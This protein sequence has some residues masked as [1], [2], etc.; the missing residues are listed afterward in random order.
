M[1]NQSIQLMPVGQSP[2]EPGWYV[3]DYIDDHNT[4]PERRVVHVVRMDEDL[5]VFDVEAPCAIPLIEFDWLFVARVFPEK[6]QAMLPATPVKQRE[7]E[8]A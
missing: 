6:V 2:V 8:D 1:T 7:S 3:V 4:I 5:Y